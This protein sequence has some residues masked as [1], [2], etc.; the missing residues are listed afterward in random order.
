MEIP[1][2]LGVMQTEKGDG[3]ETILAD[4]A[5]ILLAEGCNVGGLVQVNTHHPDGLSQAEL[6]DIRTGERYLISQPLGKQSSGCRLDPIGLCD[7]TAVLRREID[8]NV[9]LLIVN[10]FAYAEAEGKGVLQELFCALERGI[11]VLTSVASRYRP[12]WDTIIGEGGRFLDPT[13]PALSRW[14]RES[15]PGQAHRSGD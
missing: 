3:T 13:I 9:D 1:F 14:W 4:F 6:V 11:P 7:A 5:R 12:D 15:S 2:T 10:K 8:A